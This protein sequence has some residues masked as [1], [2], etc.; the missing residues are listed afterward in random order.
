MENLNDD[1]A[2]ALMSGA[3]SEK[4][5]KFP[6]LF[7]KAAIIGERPSKQQPAQI[8]NGT[9][10][11]ADLGAGPIAI[12]CQHVIAAFRERQANSPVIF[13]IGGVE[14]DPVAQLIDEN[15]RLDLATIR[16]TQEQIDAITSEGEIGSCVYKPVE[17][18]PAPLTE[19]EFVAFG[20]F[21]GELRT[22]SSYDE[23]E[24]GSWSSGASRVCSV[25]EFQFVS[26]FEREY[27][28]HSFGNKLHMGISALGGM[29]GGPALVDRGLH[30]E[31]V[32]IIYNYHENYDT[33]IF[34]SLRSLNID[35][36]I[37][38]PPG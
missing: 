3:L 5:T 26:T 35:G 14:L 32:G 8:N 6:L 11:L 38:P 9:V 16:L 27:W 31:L 30:W 18:P 28:L 22:I 7:A 12:T 23:I 24:F 4:T 1:Q 34:S 29:S 21:P 25:S 20:G 13:Q 19:G 37:Q 2:K 15:K 10:S 17:W 33:M 36:T